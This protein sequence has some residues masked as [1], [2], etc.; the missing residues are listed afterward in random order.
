MGVLSRFNSDPK[1]Q[2]RLHLTMAY[3]WA[4]NFVAAIAAYELLPKQ[5]AKFSILYLLLVSLY[6]NF[7][8]DYG[9]VAGAVAAKTA[10]N[11]EAQSV[12]AAESSTAI[13]DKLDPGTEGGIAEVVGRLEEI[14]RRLPPSG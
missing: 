5:W 10:A 4:A 6:A 7:A 2:Y 3:F 1:F 8:T 11:V 9:A 14:K 12:A 13:A